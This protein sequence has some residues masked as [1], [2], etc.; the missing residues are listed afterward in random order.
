MQDTSTQREAYE[1]DDCPR[2]ASSGSLECHGA[3]HKTGCA[4]T[5][6]SNCGDIRLGPTR[7]LA[8]GGARRFVRPSPEYC[9]I[10]EEAHHNAD[11]GVVAGRI[12]VKG[13]T[14]EEQEPW[15]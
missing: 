4:E 5:R 15:L 12:D 2:G 11:P 13:D 14:A 9:S 6:D 8:V 10:F 1:F 7:D 3:F